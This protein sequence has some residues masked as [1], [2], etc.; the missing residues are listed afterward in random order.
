MITFSLH[1]ILILHLLI[2]YDIKSSTALHYLLF[3]SSADS[4][5]Q[6][7]IGFYDFIKS[8]Y[9][10]YSKKLSNILTS[11]N[12]HNLI[13]FKNFSITKEGKEIYHQLETAL[14]KNNSYI[15]R[16]DLLH[17]RLTY[18]DEKKLF[19]EINSKI[20]YRKCRCGFNIFPQQKK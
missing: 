13:T 12:N 16:I 19:N 2:N 6:E 4:L 8:K 11:L 15:N 18:F 5:V 20:I 9:G 10:V 14:R 1:H 3:L 7:E 17:Q